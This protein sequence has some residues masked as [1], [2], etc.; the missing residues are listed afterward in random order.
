MLSPAKTIYGFGQTP[1]RPQCRPTSGF[2]SAASLGPHFPRPQFRALA[3]RRKLSIH[4][5]GLLCLAGRVMPCPPP[6]LLC[7]LGTR[8]PCPP[9]T[10]KNVSGRALLRVRLA[11]A[12][13][14]PRARGNTP[15][16]AVLWFRYRSFCTVGLLPPHPL[17]SPS[18]RRLK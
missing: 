7:T 1:Q 17:W 4:A 10:L 15:Y 14:A 9:A 12:S 5:H 16:A 2:P 8:W 18:A 6:T 3:L 11:P 13:C